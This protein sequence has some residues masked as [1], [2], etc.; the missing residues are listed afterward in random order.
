[1]KRILNIGTT[2][3]TLADLAG[4][5]YD[6]GGVL[7]AD[8]SRL[9][10]EPVAGVDGAYLLTLDAPFPESGRWWVT[11]GWPAGIGTVYSWPETNPPARSVVP[12]RQSGVAAQI[13]PTHWFGGMPSGAILTTTEGSPGA[14]DYVVT[15]W[16]AQEGVHNLTCTFGAFSFPGFSWTVQP[17]S[18]STISPAR[19]AAGSVRRTLRRHGSMTLFRH[20]T[21]IRDRKR[22]SQTWTPSGVEVTARAAMVS[23]KASREQGFQRGDQVL[24]VEGAPFPVDLDE[25]WRVVIGGEETMIA[26]PIAAQRTRPTDRASYFETILRTGG[27]ADAG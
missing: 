8:D 12:I 6:A 9:T 5:V 23:L 4:R 21:E 1:M 13:T 10:L 3:L 11:L 20:Y 7:E 27:Q 19:G 25:D 24:I 15:G 2:G 16:G 14:G 18:A 22:G 26:G 17:S